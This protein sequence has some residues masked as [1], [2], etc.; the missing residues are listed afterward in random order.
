MS[1]LDM[2]TPDY[3][4]EARKILDMTS[5]VYN[6]FRWGNDTEIGSDDLMVDEVTQSLQRAYTQGAQDMKAKAVEA[7]RDYANTVVDHSTGEDCEYCERALK[8]SELSEVES[9]RVHAYEAV[10]VVASLEVNE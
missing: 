1:T 3:A 7:V 8:N 10:D 6:G 5:H 2:P 9:N 4:A